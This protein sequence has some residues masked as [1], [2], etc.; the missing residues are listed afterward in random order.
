MLIPST[1]L[2]LELDFIINSMITEYI[3]LAN[4]KIGKNPFYGKTFNMLVSLEKNSNG[5]KI[6]FKLKNIKK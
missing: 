1:I 3:I 5:N 4:T 2:N 6:L